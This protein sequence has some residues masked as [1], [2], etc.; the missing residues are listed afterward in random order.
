MRVIIEDRSKPKSVAFVHK[1]SGTIYT[2]TV[3]GSY[4]CIPSNLVKSASDL[5]RDGYAEV[6]AG[7]RIVLEF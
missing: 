5:I 3:S 6:F 2:R 1:N 4:H 7:D